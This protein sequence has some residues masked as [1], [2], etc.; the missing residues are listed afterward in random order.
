MGLSHAFNRSLSYAFTRLEKTINA[1]CLP[2]RF[3]GIWV[4]F[5]PKCWVALHQEYEFYMAQPIK[6]GL[7]VHERVL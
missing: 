5:S 7:T 3:N 6:M 1:K 2:S 4:K